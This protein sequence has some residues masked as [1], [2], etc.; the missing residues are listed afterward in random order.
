MW[1]E[2]GELRTPSCELVSMAALQL[3]QERSLYHDPVRD[4]GLEWDRHGCCFLPRV[5]IGK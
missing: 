1:I 2:G 4:E 3:G 5:S